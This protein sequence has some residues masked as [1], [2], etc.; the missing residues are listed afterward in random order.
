MLFWAIYALDP[1][2]AIINFLK[3]KMEKYSNN[4]IIRHLGPGLIRLSSVEI[5]FKSEKQLDEVIVIFLLL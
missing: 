3:R 2:K 4:P 1:L 5:K